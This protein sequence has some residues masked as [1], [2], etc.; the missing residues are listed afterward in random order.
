[1]LS[2]G[3]GMVRRTI[4]KGSE[5]MSS[6]SDGVDRQQPPTEAW[7]CRDWGP[8]GEEDDVAALPPLLLLTSMDCE[9][10]LAMFTWC[11]RILRVA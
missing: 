7:A 1:M 4:A 3:D 6:N 2:N 8:G 5:R 11:T 9:L 10:L